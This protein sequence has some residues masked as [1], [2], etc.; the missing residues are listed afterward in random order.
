MKKQTIVFGILLISLGLIAQNP[1][2]LY[3]SGL[4]LL[5]AKQYNEAIAQFSKS[6]ELNNAYVDAYVAR[7]QSYEKIDN[8]EFCAKDYEKASQLAPQVVDYIFEAGKI[9]YR[10][11][12][13]EKA[14]TFL[15]E[16]VILDNQHF[17][18]YQ[19][20]SFTHIKLGDYKNAIVAIDNALAIQKTYVGNYTRGVANDSLQN[21]P[22]AISDYNKA[23]GLSPNFEKAYYALSKAYV[24]NGELNLALKN[25]TRSVQKFPEAPD[26]YETRSLVYY[27]RNELPEAIND[28]SKLETLVD[29]T[30]QALFTRGIY[31]FEYKQYQNAKSDFSQILALSPEKHEAIY[32]RGR[33]NEELMEDKAAGT[34]Y[35]KYMAM[36]KNNSL[37]LAYYSDAKSRLYEI[38]R[39]EVAPV[40]WIENPMVLQQNKL[41]V[42]NE[43]DRL[44]IDGKIEDESEISSFKINNQEVTIGA[45]KVFS[46]SLNIV[47]ISLVTIEL[48]DEYNNKTELEYDL[49][50]MEVDAPTVRITTPYA[51]DNNEI[52]LDSDDA[53]LFLE[54]FVED[55]SIIKDIYVDSIRATF[56][57]TELNPQ[58]SATINIE[59]KN[60]IGIKAVDAFGNV[61]ETIFTL[62]RE[63]ALIAESN[64]MGKTWV[65]FIENS[66]YE[67]FASLEGPTKDVSSMKSAL[68]SYEIHNFIHKKDMSKKEMERFFSIELRDQVKKNNVNS[69]MV[70]YA[71]HGKFI[72]ET[73]YWIPVDATRDDEFTYFNINSLK[74]GMQSYSSY[75][76]HTLVVTDACES[77]PSFYQAMRSTPEIRSCDD[78]N[79]TKFKSSQVFSS[80]GYELASDNSQFTK[81][82]AKSLQFNE[83]V[84]IPIESIVS[85][86]TEA[87]IN[88][89]NQKPLFG[90]IAGFEDEN[91][92]FFFIKK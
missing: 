25:A 89:E 3:K 69:L 63:G 77:G 43:V 54:G 42:L 28:L 47:D 23:I 59:N 81:T 48:V 26:A 27:D 83:G 6:I 65:I 24:K 18:A 76:T 62:N 46:H 60:S 38:K 80:A 78:I 22:Q 13:Y 90:K 2:K 1:K 36:A 71:G 55:A 53:N 9:N 82:F 17:Q 29:D 50:N 75:I 19:F 11:K 49:M 32:W 52:Y 72:N 33:A 92:T 70:W 15:T 87:T 12:N 57:D 74:A 5:E 84:C 4:K 7:A 8:L 51:G 68:S 35:T 10:I 66:N 58:F 79:A 45:D 16:T 21:Y 20:K 41:A 86:V 30:K 64:P 40:V 37:E 91:G 44:V 88:N 85:K 34:D 14:L 61:I 67:T 56:N 73:G 31:Y 39:E